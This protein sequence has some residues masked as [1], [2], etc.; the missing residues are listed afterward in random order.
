MK[1]SVITLI[2]AL[3]A[4]CSWAQT[5]IDEF[6]TI[7]NMGQNNDT[8][9]QLKVEEGEAIVKIKVLNYKGNGGEVNIIPRI[10]TEWSSLY[11][12]RDNMSADGTAT[13]KVKMPYTAAAEICYDGNRCGDYVIISPGKTLE[14][15]IDAS[16]EKG[17]SVVGCKGY[18]AR[19]NLELCNKDLFDLNKWL[20]SWTEPLQTSIKDCFANG[21][22]HAFLDVFDSWYYDRVTEAEGRNNSDVVK[23]LWQCQIDAQYISFLCDYGSM[24][25]G[26]I[27]RHEFNNDRAAMTTK[28]FQDRYNELYDRVDIIRRIKEKNMQ[29]LTNGTMP[30]MFS[31]F[32][33]DKYLGASAYDELFADDL[34]HDYALTYELEGQESLSENDL[35][36]YRRNDFR[37]LMVKKMR[38]QIVAGSTAP[39]NHNS[40]GVYFATHDDVAPENILQTILNKYK[41]KIVVIDLWET[42]CHPC[43]EAHK[44]M[45]DI[46][47]ELNNRDIVFVYIA[48]PLSKH[49]IWQEMIKK[50][51]GEHYYLTKSQTNYLMKQYNS[52]GVPTFAIYNKVGHLESSYIGS[53]ATTEI[54]EKLLEMTK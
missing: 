42:W 41:G 8:L 45:T 37:N 3:G 4:V 28:E 5:S 40:N 46:K 38:G 25:E 9:P 16:K 39:A 20:D 32:D 23:S 22:P 52:T 10:C 2:L 54:R 13:L 49:E 44:L 21:Q 11:S 51:S 27:V 14:L 43:L 36:R 17:C 18:L 29:S 7:E 53:T 1:Q 12:M 50:I 48:S 19:T 15:L 26:W 6:V 47:A 35:N 31:H 24:L 33:M 30:L 34:T